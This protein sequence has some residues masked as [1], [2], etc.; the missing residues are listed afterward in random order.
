MRTPVVAVLAVLTLTGC[1]GTAPAGSSHTQPS[2]GT[3][4]PSGVVTP[5]SPAPAPGAIRGVLG[6]PRS[7]AGAVVTVRRPVT[8][9]SD[10]TSYKSPTGEFVTFTVTIRNTGQQ[11]LMYGPGSF[12]L[13]DS[14]G[15]QYQQEGGG[16]Q[17]HALAPGS[18]LNPGAVVTGTVMFPGPRSGVLSYTPDGAVAPVADWAY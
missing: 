7:V 14:A 13:S 15:M 9:A 18:G 11:V 6:V 8:A 10:G 1:S 5:S 16:N 12:T 2:S 3:I 17:P 4:T